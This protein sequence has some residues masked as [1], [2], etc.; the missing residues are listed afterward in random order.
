MSACA[1]PR[2]RTSPDR[3]NHVYTRY[4]LLLREIRI[5]ATRRGNGTAYGSLPYRCQL[6][7]S[8]F[9]VSYYVL[10]TSSIGHRSTSCQKHYSSSIIVVTVQNRCNFTGA[11]SLR[12]E[13]TLLTLVDSNEAIGEG[14]Y[15]HTPARTS[16][17]SSLL[18]YRA[19]RARVSPVSR[20]S[21][22]NS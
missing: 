5:A 22:W 18:L 16:S 15:S 13:I 2:R 6:L 10:P 14:R 12:I 11:A 19:R 8:F 21:N 3:R 9:S 17:R 1:I 4:Y 7:S 20:T